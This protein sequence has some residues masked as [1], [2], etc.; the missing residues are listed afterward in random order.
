M[1]K[2]VDR[3]D[4]QKRRRVEAKI[5]AINIALEIDSLVSD[6]QNATDDLFNLTHIK[7]RTIIHGNINTMHMCTNTMYDALNGI[8]VINEPEKDKAFQILA[9]Q[10]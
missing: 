2:T 3:I 6:L 5:K 7:N 8:E 1:S 4:S 9:N 10:R